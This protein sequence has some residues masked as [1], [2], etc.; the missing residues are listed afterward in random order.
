MPKTITSPI[1]RF[2][3]SVTLFDPMTL[4]Q[5]EAI[6]EARRYFFDNKKEQGQYVSNLD[7]DKPRIPAILA[8]V[9]KW[10]LENFIPDPFPMSPQA[11][12]HKLINWLWDEIVKIYD[13]EEEIPN[14]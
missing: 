10:E 12:R 5:A 14:E 1:K 2:P 13:E 8:C 4:P 6:N 9:E 11:A 3:G 7:L